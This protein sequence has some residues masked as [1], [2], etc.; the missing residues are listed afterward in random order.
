MV[1]IRH[2]FHQI[3]RLGILKKMRIIIISLM[4]VPDSKCSSSMIHKKQLYRLTWSSKYSTTT[5]QRATNRPGRSQQLHQGCVQRGRL[6]FHLQLLIASNFFNS[7]HARRQISPPLFL[8]SK[9]QIMVLLSKSALCHFLWR[10]QASW[11]R[12]YSI[13][14][15]IWCGGAAL[16]NSR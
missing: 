8:I 15:K 10:S 1:L 4:Q 13:T 3:N 6:F 9:P 7:K 12:K 2:F 14:S 5:H 16:Q 11:H